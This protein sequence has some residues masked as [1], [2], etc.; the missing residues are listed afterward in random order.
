V[1][2]SKQ[3]VWASQGECDSQWTCYTMLWMVDQKYMVGVS[4]VLRRRFVFRGHSLY[5]GW[6]GVQRGVKILT[7][8]SSHINAMLLEESLCWLS[9]NSI[10]GRTLFTSL[11]IISLETVACS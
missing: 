4:K 6:T 2:R 7:F 5:S 3:E 10:S 9:M 8:V 1:H 11:H